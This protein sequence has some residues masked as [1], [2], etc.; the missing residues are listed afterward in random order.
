MFDG[1]SA[2]DKGISNFL[3]NIRKDVIVNIIRLPR[4]KDI[5]DL[6]YDEVESLI[7]NQLQKIV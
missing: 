1:D 3:K 2:G 6:S 4:G 7:Q 5:N